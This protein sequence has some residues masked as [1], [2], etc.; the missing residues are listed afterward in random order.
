MDQ[1]WETPSLNSRRSLTSVARNPVLNA[2]KTASM[3]AGNSSAIFREQQIAAAAKEPV[4][5]PTR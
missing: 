4:H 2:T 5:K 3:A 1:L